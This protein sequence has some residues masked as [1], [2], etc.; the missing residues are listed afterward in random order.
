MTIDPKLIEE[1][2]RWA[3]RVG[4]V[5]HP[6]IEVANTKTM[7]LGVVAVRAVKVGETLFSCPHSAYIAPSDEDIPGCPAARLIASRRPYIDDYTRVVLRVLAEQARLPRS[8]WKAWLQC[9]SP[10]D[11]SILVCAIEELHELRGSSVYAQ[12][13]EMNI[14]GRWDA[15]KQFVAENPEVWPSASK[16]SFS[17][18]AALVSSR[19]FHIEERQRPGP[20]LL[21]GID[22]I[23]HSFTAHNVRFVL[24]GTSTF[25]VVSSKDIAPGQQILHNYGELSD[26]RFLVEFGFLPKAN[27]FDCARFSK[28]QLAN[29][30]CAVSDMA[31]EV[32]ESRLAFLDRLGFIFEEGILALQSEDPRRWTIGDNEQRLL[33]TLYLLT[34]PEEQ[35]NAIVGEVARWWHVP[36]ADRCVALRILHLAARHCLDHYPRSV[37]ACTSGCV[38]PELEATV[39]KERE[40]FQRMLLL[41][42]ALTSN[43]VEFV[44]KASDSA[45]G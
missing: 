14:G 28:V 23:N 33:D 35:Y 41:T 25:D 13:S 37:P 9:I 43:E 31:K 18:C 8:P 29:I 17:R 19:N 15:V 39:G 30:A 3:K 16:D 12:L 32:V 5:V 20:F 1:W 34:L 26:A 36:E 38:A 21:P 4:L 11:H 45:D 22:F 6:S 44:S 2:R 7:G 24:R 10:L 40:R 27:P 42:E